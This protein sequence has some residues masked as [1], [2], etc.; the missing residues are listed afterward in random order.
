[1]NKRKFLMVLAVILVII[2]AGTV[3]F[4]E[5]VNVKTHEYSYADKFFFNISDDLTDESEF[6]PSL[7]DSFEGGTY[8]S[9]PDGKSFC[10]LS[11]EGEDEPGDFE[12]HLN[13]SAY[14]KID[15]NTTSQGYNAY[16]F[17][18][19]NEYTVFIDLDNMTVAFK[20]GYDMEYNYFKATFESL[21]EATIFI[22]TFKVN[23]TAMI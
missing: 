23:E 7:F 4:A 12:S 20:E 5:S 19:S 15:A 13:D 17:R 21:D 11:V 14:E 8:Y 16:I 10:S 18:D 9:Y 3:V 22:D 1:M 2:A 6:M